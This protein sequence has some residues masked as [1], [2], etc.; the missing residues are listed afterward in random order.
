M[1]GRIALLLCAALL[2]G[3]AIGVADTGSRLSFWLMVAAGFVGAWGCFPFSQP[4]LRRH[5][6]VGRQ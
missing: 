3:A 1:L 6:D 2:I 5:K 4:L